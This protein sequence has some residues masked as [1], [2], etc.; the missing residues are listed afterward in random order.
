M[1]LLLSRSWGIF[2]SLAVGRAG[3]IRLYAEMFVRLQIAFAAEP[4]LHGRLEFVQ[5]HA[6]ARFEKAV[7]S[8]ERVIEDGVVG[9]VAHGEVVDPLDGARVRVA[10]GIDTFDAEFAGKHRV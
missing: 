1:L 5:R 4:V 2:S 10:F 6:G 9:E 8:G 7:G 3:L